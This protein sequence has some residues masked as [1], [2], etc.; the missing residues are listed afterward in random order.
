MSDENNDSKLAELEAK[1]TEQADRI[2]ELSR[3]NAKFD[4]ELYPKPYQQLLYCFQF[5]IR[6]QQ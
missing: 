6:L 5:D 1:L 3:E 2:A 4:R